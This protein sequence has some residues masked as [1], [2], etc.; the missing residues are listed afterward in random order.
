MVHPTMWY[1]LDILTQSLF[2]QL[3]KSQETPK[4]A[5]WID[6]G[7][8]AREWISPAFCLWFIGHVSS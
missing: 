2:C 8:H 1:T 3:S 5:I 7:I 4:S 6:C